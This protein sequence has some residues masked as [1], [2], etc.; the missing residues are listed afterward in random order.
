MSTKN[1]RAGK[2][3][4]AMKNAAKNQAG[5]GVFAGSAGSVL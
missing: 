3:S 1:N 2:I 4:G 5:T